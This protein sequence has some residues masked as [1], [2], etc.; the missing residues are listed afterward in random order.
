MAAIKSFWYSIDYI[1]NVIVLPDSTITHCSISSKAMAVWR[2]TN[3]IYSNDMTPG[4][5]Y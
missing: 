3:F 5:L 1:I 2:I 4:E